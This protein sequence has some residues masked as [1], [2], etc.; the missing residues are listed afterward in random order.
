MCVHVK[1]VTKSIKTFIYKYQAVTPY[2]EVRVILSASAITIPLFEQL[3]VHRTPEDLPPLLQLE[4]WTSTSG[5][6]GD[7]LS[8]AKETKKKDHIKGCTIRL[9]PE[10]LSEKSL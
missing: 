8:S 6:R 7:C 5:T 10:S 1:N 4:P 9:N 2:G 3:A